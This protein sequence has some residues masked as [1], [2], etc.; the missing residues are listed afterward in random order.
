V[1]KNKSSISVTLL[2]RF[3]FAENQHRILCKGE[4]DFFNVIYSKDNSI[5]LLSEEMCLDVM[6]WR[7]YTGWN[8]R[9]LGLAG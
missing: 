3:S 5:A 8:D 4:T 2:I 9:G 7:L 1:Y 6:V